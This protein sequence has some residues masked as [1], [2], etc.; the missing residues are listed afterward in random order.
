[1]KGTPVAI[2][3]LA[4][5]IPTKAILALRGPLALTGISLFRLFPL[6]QSLHPL[7]RLAIVHDFTFNSYIVSS[8]CEATRWD[9]CS[10]T[11]W[12]ENDFVEFRTRFNPSI[13]HLHR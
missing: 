4:G 3:S 11:K 13:E 12:I 1:M 6:F 7:A 5:P 10:A 2:S 9:A 8:E